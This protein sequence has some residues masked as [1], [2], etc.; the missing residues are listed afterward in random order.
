ML[1][2]TTV[3]KIIASQSFRRLVRF[4]LAAV[5]VYAGTVK[6]LDPKAFSKVLSLYGII[7]EGFLPVIAIGLPAV[8]ALAG[9]GLIFN[10]RGS[11]FAILSLLLV[12]CTVLG[13]GILNDLNIDCGC[14]TQDE[15]GQQNSLKIALY[16]DLAMIGA[17][18]FLFLS[19]TYQS[20]RHEETN[21]IE[22]LRSLK[23]RF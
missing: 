9:L 10:V 11:L 21:F 16:R 20:A 8:E 18:C 12:F 22:K 23:G 4:G 19:R 1:A 17:V 2:L 14:F 15:I 7:P 13:Y 5:F 6:L 3:K